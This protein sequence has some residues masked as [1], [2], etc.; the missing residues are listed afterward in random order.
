M[1]IAI[2]KS[3]ASSASANKLRCLANSQAN[4]VRVA[5]SAD[6]AGIRFMNSGTAQQLSV[7]I[8]SSRRE[9]KKIPSK[10]GFTLWRRHL[11][12]NGSKRRVTA[13]SSEIDQTQSGEALA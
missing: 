5:R 4:R 2:G 11:V 8:P 9:A 6:L 12:Q 10:D 1:P 3:S 13:S 7:A